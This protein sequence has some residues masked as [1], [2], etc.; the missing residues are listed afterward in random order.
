MIMPCF[1][2]G[3]TVVKKYERFFSLIRISADAFTLIVSYLLSIMLD[4]YMDIYHDHLPCHPFAPFWMVPLLLVA[5]MVAGLYEPLRSYRFGKEIRMVIKAHAIGLGVIF[6]ALF[7]GPQYLPHSREAA[8]YFASIGLT[9]MLLERISVRK[10][11]RFMRRKGY[12]Q[13]FLLMIGANALGIDFVRKVRSHPTFGYTLIGFL[14]DDVPPG[15]S[16][17]GVRVLGPS[18]MLPTML[19]RREVD[20]VVSVLPLQQADLHATFV[21][22]CEKAGVR[23]RIIPDYSLFLPHGFPKIDDFDGVPVLSVRK[24][25]LDDPTLKLLKRAFDIVFSATALTCVSP[26]MIAIAIG[27]KLTSPGPLL[28]RQ[29]RIGLN[30]RTFDMLK[31]RSMRVD[32][33]ETASTTWTTANDPRK[34]RFGAFLRKTSLDELP[35]FINVLMG[36]MSVIGPRPERP[37]FVEQFREEVPL[38]MVKHQVRPGITG[39]AQVNGWRGDTS[40]KKR[41][42]CDLYYIENWRVL[43]DLK[44]IFLT[45]SKGLVNK[46]AY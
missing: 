11:L 14:D 32:K 21:Q 25:P 10:W 18:S 30:N 34:T 36:D 9:L 2:G 46:N 4:S 27:I 19:E 26:L 28:F 7:I 5:Y 38:Y 8:V 24:V 43:L 17:A 33:E 6:S 44:I 20:E 35:Q 15:E 12:N 13:K 29:Q 45:I 37:F 39:W 40:I 16:V 22:I 23:I 42:E 1:V 3:A 31:F 41:I